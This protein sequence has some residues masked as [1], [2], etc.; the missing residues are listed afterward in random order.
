MTTQVRVVV[1]RDGNREDAGTFDFDVIPETG[2]YLYLPD[3]RHV[4]VL[5]RS[6]V[7]V[8]NSMQFELLVSKVEH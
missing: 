4:Y 6:H 5:Q 1:S 8:G 3:G 7:A 2:D